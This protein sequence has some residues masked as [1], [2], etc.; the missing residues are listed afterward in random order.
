MSPLGVP[1]CNIEPLISR[2]EDG[3]YIETLVESGT[4]EGLLFLC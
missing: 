4:S 3:Q 2:V 1:R